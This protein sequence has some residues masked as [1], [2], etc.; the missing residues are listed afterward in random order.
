MAF[1]RKEWIFIIFAFAVIYIVWG[2]TYLGVKIAIQS[3]PPILMGGSRYFL[4]GF[5]L[6]LINL[7]FYRKLP[8][9]QA[10][11]NAVFA[12]VLFVACGTGGLAWSLQFVDTGIAALIIAGQPL[13]TL[14]YVWIILHQPPTLSSYI[15]IALGIAGMALLVLQDQITTASSSLW[16]IAVI[17]FGMLCWGYGS[18]FIKKADLPKNQSQNAAIQMMAGGL[19]LIPIGFLLG[20]HR[21][22]QFGS[23]TTEAVGA[24]AYLV[25][26]GSI[27]GFSCFNYL[28]KKVSPEKVA[29][30]TYVNPVVALILGWWWLGEIVTM[31]S[32]LAGVIMLTGVLFINVD[33]L[34]FWRKS[35]RKRKQNALAKVKVKKL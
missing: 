11:R 20:E 5:I 10:F 25:F 30:S 28:L 17:A 9:T 6:Y 31:R 27:L 16:G 22:F 8:T 33:M 13:L 3:I 7:L 12:G 19:F 1:S 26:F 34:N 21:G 4:G 24:M 32:I 14:F 2:T 29:T 15:G 23:I 35:I 18:V